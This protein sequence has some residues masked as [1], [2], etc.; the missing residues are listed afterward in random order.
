MRTEAS[1]AAPEFCA[2]SQA[3]AVDEATLRIGMV[4]ASLIV[5]V[6]SARSTDGLGAVPANHDGDVTAATAAMIS[7]IGH[8]IPRNIF[9]A[10]GARS[11]GRKPGNAGPDRSQTR[12]GAGSQ[13]G[14]NEFISMPGL[15]YMM[16]S[17][18]LGVLPATDKGFLSHQT[19]DR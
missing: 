12:D 13:I 17:Q 9:T 3:T 16:L 14:P 2:L 19:A 7:P 1:I 11:C 10:S 6:P 8:F 15:I 5:R 4:A 18:P